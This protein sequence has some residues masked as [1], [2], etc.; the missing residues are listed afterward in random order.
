MFHVNPSIGGVIMDRLFLL[1]PA[2]LLFAIFGS[3]LVIYGALCL[4]GH[5]PKVTGVKHN[6]LFGPF[7]AS[8]LVWLIGPIERRLV[9]R[10]SPNAI[11]ALSLLLS[12]LTG[13]AAG[14][15]HLGT[16]V[17][18][19][20]FAGIADVLDGRLARLSGKQTATGALFDSISDRWGELC[21]FAGYAWFLHDSPWLLAV[22]AAIAGSMMVSYTRARAEALGVALTGGIMQRAE[23]LVL[24]ALGTLAAAWYGDDP[25][26]AAAIVPIVGMTM[27]VCGVASI[28]TA[29][30]RWLAAHRALAHGGEP[31]APLVTRPARVR[32]RSFAKLST[33]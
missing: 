18:L 4:A 14:T 22:M 6:Q 19:Y 1:A 23:R 13:L 2:L 11:T 5:A 29:L 32:V 15:G 9:G 8:F 10:I 20:A 26:N 3:A 7:F 28:A 16:A 24:I 25:A 33:R 31:D 17:W 30:A 27:L 21:M 12:V